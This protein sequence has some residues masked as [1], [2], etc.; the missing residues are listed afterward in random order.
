MESERTLARGGYATGIF[1]QDSRRAEN[2]PKKKC[3]HTLIKK[4][5]TQ[6]SLQTRCLQVWKKPTFSPS[7]ALEWL[8]HIVN[9]HHFPGVS[10][11]LHIHPVQ[12]TQHSDTYQTQC[13]ISYTVPLDTCILS[14]WGLDGGN[15]SYSNTY[16]LTAL[17]DQQERN[18]LHTLA[19]AP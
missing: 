10:K 4:Q 3:R 7:L 1:G 14:I 6:M 15:Y 11:K 17:I 19:Q 9:Q 16:Q 2:R 12:Q 8:C 5:P 18:G 13:R